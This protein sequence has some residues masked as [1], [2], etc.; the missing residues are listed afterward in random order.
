[1]S[2]GTVL[3]C[4]VGIYQPYT[5]TAVKDGAGNSFTQ[6]AAVNYSGTT[7]DG[8]TSLWALAT[9]AGDVGT[10]PV[11]T[12]TLAGS[13]TQFWSMVLQEVSGIQAAADGTAGVSSGVG[14]GANV[15][16]GA[17]SSASA[18]E[19]L[20]ALYSDDLNVSFTNVNDPTGSTTYALDANSQGNASNN[21]LAFAYGNSTGGAET[22]TFSFSATN[23]G[24]SYGTF[25][26][27]FKLAGGGPSAGPAIHL[28]AQ[29]LRA[30]LHSQ[31]QQVSQPG[32]VYANSVQQVP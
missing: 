27:A 19:Y 29:A 6:I 21:I 9:P 30:R 32:L 15:A 25:L 4:A 13:G 14:T 11:L 16:C 26:V 18:S 24:N 23:S 7:G 22:A 17:Y 2:S 8:Q 3:L 10:K 5:V 12:A 31:A 1:M 20:I 28:P